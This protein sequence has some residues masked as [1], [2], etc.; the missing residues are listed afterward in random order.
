MRFTA[1]TL[2]GSIAGFFADLGRQELWPLF[3]HAKKR[4]AK[5][6]KEEK[7]MKYTV[8]IG[9]FFYSLLFIMRG[10]THFSKQVIGYAASQGVP[11]AS[12]AVPFSGLM[13]VAG[14]LSILLGYRAK[15]DAWVLVLFLAPVTVMMHSF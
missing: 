8:A 15:V 12:I 9:R 14:G 6:W 11:F 2:E 10:M 1:K 4:H 7:K 3:A 5:A 13:A